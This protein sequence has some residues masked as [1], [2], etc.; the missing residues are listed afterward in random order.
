M[1]GELQ[2]LAQLKQLD[3]VMYAQALI[4]GEG[5]D[6]LQVYVRVNRRGNCTSQAHPSRAELLL[7]AEG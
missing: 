5:I 2:L 3:L 6:D 7:S 1:A 4:Q